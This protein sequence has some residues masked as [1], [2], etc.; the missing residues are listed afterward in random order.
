MVLTKPAAGHPSLSRFL[1][2]SQVRSNNGRRC[3]DVE[4]S[5][6]INVIHW[7]WRLPSFVG[8]SLFV[9][10]LLSGPFAAQAQQ[11]EPTSA[12]TAQELEELAAVMEDEA[13]REQLLSRIRTLIATT[14]NTEV[15][16]PVESTGARLI[17][18]LSE[19]V[20]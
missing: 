8:A 9:V 14:G 19:N 2:T 1:L 17:A 7:N 3:D 15:K 13:A 5:M 16:P 6:N 4:E 18:V 11:A 10:F 12:V 20:E